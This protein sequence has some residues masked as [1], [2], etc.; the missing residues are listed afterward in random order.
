M[1]PSSAPVQE[2]A[3][4]ADLLRQQAAGW[5]FLS[6]L[7][8]KPPEDRRIGEAR[9]FLATFG[10]EVGSESPEEIRADYLRLFVGLKKALAPPWESV[11]LSPS[12]LVFQQ[13]TLEVRR[14]YLEAAFSHDQM[15]EAPDDHVSLELEFLAAL[16]ERIAAALDAGNV[17]D[18]DHTR[19][20]RQRFLEHHLDLWVG[21]FARDILTYSTTSFWKGVATVLLGIFP[22]AGFNGC[23]ERCRGG[24]D[25]PLPA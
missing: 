7:L 16:N 13:P 10:I 14:A 22:P 5:R 19:S 25:N 6:A 4:T 12:G 20:L 24:K 18:A 1:T 9:T 3:E 8:A 11:Y 23:G 17:A 21:A 15:F 2:Q